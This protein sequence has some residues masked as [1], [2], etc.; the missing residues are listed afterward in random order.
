MRHPRS[1]GERGVRRFWQN[2][3]ARCTARC[4][5]VAL[6]RRSCG[7]GCSGSEAPAES[8]ARLRCTALIRSAELSKFGHDHNNSTE[9]IK[10]S[11][12]WAYPGSSLVRRAS[13]EFLEAESGAEPAACGAEPA[14]GAPIR[15]RAALQGARVQVGATTRRRSRAPRGV[16]R[17]GDVGSVG[18]AQDGEGG[19]VRPGSDPSWVTE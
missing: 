16:V 15:L 1:C 9:R 2:L 4:C 12:V 3:T 13:P 5:L 7:S 18:G 10:D 6:F 8:S 14:G 17:R 19:L 11:M